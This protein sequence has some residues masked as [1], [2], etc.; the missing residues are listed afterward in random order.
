MNQSES[1][2]RNLVALISASVIFVLFLLIY[3]FPRL[4]S[5]NETEQ[6]VDTLLSLRQEVSVILPEVGRTAPTTPLPEPDVRTWI[7]SNTFQGIEQNMAAN[8]GYLQGQG[9]QVKLKRLTA[10]QTARFMSS[11]TKVR[12]VVERMQLQD[13]DTDGRWDLEINLKVP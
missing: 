2:D 9:A 5:L 3:F 4:K 11:L 13:S 1:L 8:D 10:E 6:S 7:A 12:L